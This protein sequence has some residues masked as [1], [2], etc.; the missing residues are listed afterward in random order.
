MNKTKVMISGESYKGC[1]ILDDGHMVFVVE[2]LVETQCS[3]L[4]I[5]NGCTG[6]VMV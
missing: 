1:R 2:V 5:R 3:A 6:S 4:T